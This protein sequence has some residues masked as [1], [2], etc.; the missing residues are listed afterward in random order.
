MQSGSAVVQS[1]RRQRVSDGAG[2][3]PQRAGTPQ[4]AG[5]LDDSCR[6]KRGRLSFFSTKALRKRDSSGVRGW[7]NE[8]KMKD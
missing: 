2:A 3:L 5:R 4:P 8:G 7:K 1:A 6:M